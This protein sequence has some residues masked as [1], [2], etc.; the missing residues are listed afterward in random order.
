MRKEGDSRRESSDVRL[1]KASCLG[2][3]KMLLSA[4]TNL[5]LFWQGPE[6]GENNSTLNEMIDLE[7]LSYENF[8]R[9]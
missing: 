8:L 4:P 9:A 5:R 6:A 3:L 7:D 1:E 2:K